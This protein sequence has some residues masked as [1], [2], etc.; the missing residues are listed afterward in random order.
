MWGHTGAC[1]DLGSSGAGQQVRV[2]VVTPGPKRHRGS[3]AQSAGVHSIINC[4]VLG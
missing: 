3:L 4:V 2:F 1:C